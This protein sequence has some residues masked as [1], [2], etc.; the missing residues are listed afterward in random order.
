[1]ADFPHKLLI[2]QRPPH[3][4]S[5]SHLTKRLHRIVRHRLI[6]LVAPAGYGK[7]ALLSDFANDSTAPPVCWYS[8]DHFDE[9]PWVFLD[10]LTLTI[11][12]RF[13]G[14]TE[15]TAMLL[16]RPTHI[17]FETVVAS[18][19]RDISAI[20]RDLVIIFDDWHLIDHVAAINL[21]V[22]RLLRQCPNCHV[23]L[24]SRSAPSLPDLLPSERRR[25][26]SIDEEHLR[27]T[28]PEIAALFDAAGHDPLSPEQA[29]AL[30]EQAN[31]WIIAI[32]MGRHATGTTPPTIH[33]E[34][35]IQRF[36]AEQ[37]FDRQPPEVRA[38]LLD[39]ALL[40]ELTVERCDLIRARTDS[41]LMLEWLV[42]QHLFVSTI[43]PGVLRYHPMFREFLRTHV[44]TTEPQRYQAI[45]RR[46]AA[47]YTA[48]QQW[49][50]AFD[51]FVAAG[52][53][54]AA[55]AIAAATA[56]PL[57]DG[58]R[59]ETLE[60][61]FAAL[62]EENLD[63]P[64]LCLKAHVLIDRGHGDEAQRL[65]D[66][67]EARQRPIDMPV[68]MLV[69][70][71]LARLGGR[72]ESAIAILRQILQITQNLAHQ[73][74]A[75]RWLAICHHQSG[76]TM[77]TIEELNRALMIQLQRDDHNAVALLQYDL[78]IC[79]RMAGMLNEA[80]KFA[81]EAD[82]YWLRSDNWLMRA[83]TLNNI[84]IVQ[85]LLG[86]YHEAQAKLTMALRYARES[87]VP[88]H[89]A[90]VLASLGNLYSDM[91][92]WERARAAYFDAYRFSGS[93]YQRSNIE[94]A[95][96]ELLVRRRQYEAA[97]RELRKLPAT[98]ARYSASALLVLR[99]RI[100]YGMEDYRQAREMVDQAI[101]ALERTNA[102]MDLARAYLLQARIIASAAP[103]ERRALLAALDQAARIADQLGHDAFLV[104]ETSHM[105]DVLRSAA[106]AGWA[107]AS[108]WLQRHWE[109]QSARRWRRG[110][111]PSPRK[112]DQDGNID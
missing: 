11:A 50:L 86:H 67:A 71:D 89:Q 1:M 94:L 111:Y 70:A 74:A 107:R 27:F 62:P 85:H 23:V 2:P 35:E 7:T 8:L 17:S 105:P 37:V 64:L 36:L 6:M 42:Q 4:V 78:S 32:L 44:R 68:V 93:E 18:L 98:N 5:R 29:Q 53:L 41:E 60:R 73:A 26:S 109:M 80:Q 88:R 63:A 65:T 104:A 20:G 69:Q 57:Y 10:Y 112:S 82:D 30:I 14:A 87:A 34:R 54:V 100:A 103:V 79:Y 72:Y 110:P 59:L 91:Q 51:V 22:V 96:V 61:W 76:Q 83:L 25:I 9:D 49:S 47:S 21:T 101:A 43:R 13:P 95:L 33:A 48:Q 12:R 102:P 16:N 92:R 45:A 40:E 3:L 90:T 55:Q 58:G 19:V 15:Q 28:A 46:L 24:A 77:H 39:T 81:K 97:A 52:D 75:L 108:D 38:F 84:G 31:G 56:E 66:L 106:S 99:G